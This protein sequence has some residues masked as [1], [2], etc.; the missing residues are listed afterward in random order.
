MEASAHSQVR[1]NTNKVKQLQLLIVVLALSNVGL[2]AFSY[3]LLRELDREYS[4][5]IGQSVPVLNSLQT[6][7]AKAMEAMRATNPTQFG[8]QADRASAFVQ[9]AGGRFAADKEERLKALKPEWAGAA[10]E[11]NELSEAGDGFTRI[12]GEVLAHYAS[13]RVDEA[14]R[15]REG[16][17]RVAFDRYIAAATKA[18]DVLEVESTKLNSVLSARADNVSSVVLG[19][20]TWPLILLLGI[21]TTALLLV[22]VFLALFRGRDISGAQ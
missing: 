4:V 16:D 15:L 13:G 14:V 5:V 10:A 7:T 20:G 11:R 17:L 21:L 3:Y 12:G 18:A 1:R 9:Q 6:L 19:I 2:G 8:R 22:A